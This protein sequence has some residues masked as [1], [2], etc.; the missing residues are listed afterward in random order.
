MLIGDFLLLDTGSASMIPAEKQASIETVLLSHAH[1][2]HI[3]E[4]G[5]MLDA[6]VASRNVPLRVMG[7]K[8]CLDI[9]HRHY[10]NDLIWPDFSRIKTSAGPTLEYMNLEDRNWIELP[11]GLSLWVEP[12]NHSSGARGFIF[13]SESGSIVYTGDT[14]PTETIWEKA[15]TLSDLKFIVAEVSFPNSHSEL[16]VAGSHMS[17]KLLADEL[18]KLGNDELPVY[19][20]HLKPWY[21][22]E[23][24]KDLAE[25]FEKRVTVLKRGDTLNF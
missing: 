16:A 22:R 18:R 23:I 25:T 17:P 4:L 13:R 9:V 8:A 7:S 5:F 21:R 14:G 10:M 1:L 2:D 3:L 19:A 12:V 15:S 24:E 11:G 6:T 20:F